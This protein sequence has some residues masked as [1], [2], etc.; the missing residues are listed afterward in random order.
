MKYRVYD[1]ISGQSSDIEAKSPKEAAIK[2][3]ETDP[4]PNSGRREWIWNLN[5]C[6]V[7][8]LKGFID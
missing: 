5:V 8:D 7:K 2:Y 4:E 3:L 6:R 1:E